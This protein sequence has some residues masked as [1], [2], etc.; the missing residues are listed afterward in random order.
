[1][2]K[3]AS[4][5]ALII[6]VAVS[7]GCA[8]HRPPATAG[9]ISAG[10]DR[11]RGVRLDGGFAATVEA[12]D[13]VLS[14]ALQE[15]AI[16]ASADRH[17]RVAERYFQLR[18][19]DSAYDHFARARDLSPS[20]SAAYLGLARVWREWGFAN[21]GLDDATRGVHYAPAQPAAHNT[22]GTILLALGRLSDARLAFERA[23]ALDPDAPY[24]LNNLC[25]LSFLE[26][27]VA[28]AMTQCQAAL[29]AEPHFIAARN[30]LALVYAAS[31]REDLALREFSAAGD[32]AAAS[33]NI[34]LVRQAEGHYAAAAKAF[35]EA[36]RQRPTWSAAR[37]RAHQT[38]R[39]AAAADRA[40]G[41]R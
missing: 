24:P 4:I 25:Y 12:Q 15:L 28:Q 21:R 6:A 13:P 32:A 8:V 41:T 31:E 10:P 30:N 22:L 2:H 5:G 27:D 35:D 26:G 29:D 18:I 7:V 38:H 20:D 34:G 36:S 40:L 39:L 3:Q 1:M 33:Y 9:G 16:T 14:A 37:V 23:R 17:C 19:F 11:T